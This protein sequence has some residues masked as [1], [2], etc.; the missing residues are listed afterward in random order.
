MNSV[1][2]LK[3]LSAAKESHLAWLDYGLAIL[4]GDDLLH[5][6]QPISCT[7]CNFGLWYYSKVDLLRS[8]KGFKEIELLHAEFHHKYDVLF[9][10][11]H[12]AHKPRL[13]GK[14]KLLR[15]LNED[16]IALGNESV[17]LIKKLEE[18]ETRIHAKQQA[19]QGAA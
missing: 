16:Y 18:V 6:Q 12:E 13:F 4:N 8:I 10:H 7:D 5:V 11:A 15:Q 2:I 3:L 1:E 17:L 14:K 19:E 9:T